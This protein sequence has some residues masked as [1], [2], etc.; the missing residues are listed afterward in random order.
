MYAKILGT[1]FQ[2]F[3]NPIFVRNVI[4]IYLSIGGVFTFCAQI[5]PT[6]D[7]CQLKVGMGLAGIGIAEGMSHEEVLR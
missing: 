2:D 1:M 7:P 4:I 3:R 6:T 5:Q